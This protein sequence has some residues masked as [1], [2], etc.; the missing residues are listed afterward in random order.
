L[1]EKAC[2]DAVLADT[3]S[4]ISYAENLLNLAHTQGSALALP[5]P[6]LFGRRSSLVTRIHHILQADRQQVY[7]D[8]CGVLPGLLLAAILVAPYSAFGITLHIIEHQRTDSVL[9]KVN[10]IPKESQE[11]QQYMHEFGRA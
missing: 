3:G 2:D 4:A 7:D 9:F 1:R 10:Y 8:R 11:Y 5:V 6:A